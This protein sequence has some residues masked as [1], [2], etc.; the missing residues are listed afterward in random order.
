MRIA[1]TNWSRRVVGGTEGYI[2]AV[3]PALAARGLEV[4]LWTEQDEPTDRDDTQRP[5]DDHLR[6]HG[7]CQGI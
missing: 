2:Q 3:I 5:G 4:A 6:C 7:R 1:I